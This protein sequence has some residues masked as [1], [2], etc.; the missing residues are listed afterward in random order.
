MT[1]RQRPATAAGV[2]FLN[3]EDEFGLINVVVSRGC[4]QHH[5]QV[6][7]TASALIVRGRVEIAEGVINLV[8]DKLVEYATVVSAGD[9]PI[10]SR[11]FR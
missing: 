5:Q 8:A 7:L 9:V 10:G 1:H 3:L 11:D 6:A 2:T 4:W